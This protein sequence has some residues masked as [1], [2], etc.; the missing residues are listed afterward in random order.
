MSRLPVIL[1]SAVLCTAA[2]A[3]GGDDKGGNN[4][5]PS[6]SATST[7]PSPTPSAMTKEAWVAEANKACQTV[8]DKSDKIA[9][10]TT[11]KEYASGTREYLQAVKDAQASL[12]A[13]TPPA[14]DAT[15]IEENFLQPNDQQIAILE[16]V[17][18]KVDAA[19]AKNDTEA[20]EAALGEAFTE[21]Q[22]ISEKIEKWAAP[23]GLTAC[24]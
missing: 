5:A 20:A 6:A 3:C 2:L 8:E 15:A 22:P 11:A 12:R 7:T 14:A 24:V 1:A 23:Y 4:A 18:P 9:D 10:P 13:L 17:L 16:R 21:F 19:A